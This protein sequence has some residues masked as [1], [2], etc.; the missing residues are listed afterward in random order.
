ME[1]YKSGASL[2]TIIFFVFLLILAQLCCNGGDLW[3]TYWTKIEETRNN[4]TS[5]F[6]TTISPLV[7]N[8]SNTVLNAFTTI[9]SLLE[10]DTRTNNSINA[11]LEQN[12][13]EL[14]PQEYYMYIYTL[15]II[16]SIIFTTGRSLLFFKIAM[17]ASIGL[18]NKMFS[19]ILQAPMRFF[20]TNPSGRILNRF[21]KDMGAVDELL[22]KAMLDAIQV[23][24]V[25]FGI[26]MMVFIVT[27]WMIALAIVLGVVFFWFRL[28]YLRSAQT[29]KRL[30]GV[31]RAPVFSHV[32][33][34]L[35]GLPTIR[36]SNAQQM[37]IDEFDV[38][39][40][41]HTGTWF[42]YIA[43]SEAFGFYLDI[44]SVV[45]LTIL[46]FQFLIF[47]DGTHFRQQFT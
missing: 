13:A 29:I 17:N 1:Y 6:V 18:H 14:M 41:Q 42:L 39:Q 28:V 34:S 21:S 3:L 2:I 15:L 10:N 33:S 24:L 45:F 31:T 47:N 8:S 9:T 20:D 23:F 19:C 36:A 12:E 46:T 5:Q 22:P 44:I 4:V 25:M 32:S 43:A 27:P 40:D 37:I 35:F 26:L 38:L 11:L 7:L 16:A 30:E